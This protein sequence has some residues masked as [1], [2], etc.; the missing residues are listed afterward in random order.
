MFSCPECG[1]EYDTEEEATA[2]CAVAEEPEPEEEV[3]A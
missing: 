3:T 2:C 1:A